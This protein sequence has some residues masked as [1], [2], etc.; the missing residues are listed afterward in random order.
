MEVILL[1]VFF[2]I[3]IAGGFLVAYLWGMKS[4]QFEDPDAQAFRMLWDA[5][6]PS[7][8]KHSSSKE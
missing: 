3:L 4:G 7:E 5:S 2:S 8:N 6:A 1:L